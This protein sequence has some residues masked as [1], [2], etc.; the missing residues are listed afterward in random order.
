[1]LSQV[2]RGPFAL[3]SS[4]ETNLEELAR[5]APITPGEIGVNE[6]SLRGTPIENQ[7]IVAARNLHWSSPLWLH[8]ARGASKLAALPWERSLSSLI[9]RSLLRIPNFLVSPFEPGEEARIAICASWPL[10][11]GGH[12][13]AS[14]I[15]RLLDA[16]SRSAISDDGWSRSTF[17]V[18]VFTDLETYSLFAEQ[19]GQSYK[20]LNVHFHDPRNAETEWLSSSSDE[21]SRIEQTSRIKNPWLR[22]MATTSRGVGVDVVHFICPGYFFG[23]SGA[24]A[25]AEHPLRNFNR[26]WSRF[27][28]V[29]ELA[30]FYDQV[31][32]STMGFTA[33]GPVDWQAG[34]RIL[35]Y[36]LSWLRSGPVLL[37]GGEE[38]G[39]LVNAY[40]ALFRSRRF[41]PTVSGDLQFCVHPDAL[42][43]VDLVDLVI[44]PM[45]DFNATILSMER[46]GTVPDDRVL[47]SSDAPKNPEL[48]SR[49]GRFGGQRGDRSRELSQQILRGERANLSSIKP[50]SE[51]DEA[52][53]AGAMRALDFIA[54]LTQSE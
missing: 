3:G 45:T 6:L 14:S 4:L 9:G 34:L 2:F 51:L 11:K 29:K 35:A 47:S 8:I 26:D 44:P 40:S 24:I 52:R 37:D 42:R 49:R 31:G 15:D 5:S 48:F 16:L 46:S 23:D 28:G 7:L 33:I 12:E 36:E 39:P 10:A 50:K 27:V 30:K 38:V 1:M 54:Q 20:G 41:D 22:W 32:C 13:V 19:F 21:M 18:D 25:L 53:D 43:D 17:H